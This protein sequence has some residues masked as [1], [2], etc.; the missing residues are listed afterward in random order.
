MKMVA[1]RCF[2]GLDRGSIL[3]EV[4]S[5]SSSPVRCRGLGVW[6]VPVSGLLSQA[7]L[8]RCFCCMEGLLCSSRLAEFGPDR[9]ERFG[10]CMKQ[11]HFS[12][13]F[14]LFSGLLC[15][16]ICVLTLAAPT[17]LALSGKIREFPIPTASSHPDGITAGPDG[18]L[19]F[20]EE[21]GN[22]IGQLR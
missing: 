13:R 6:Q 8:V 21:V 17:A 7:P 1:D 4:I 2:E 3:V 10:V 18:N 22:K 9:T 19:W 16:L 11:R 14:S 20:T 12:L 5:D 15:L